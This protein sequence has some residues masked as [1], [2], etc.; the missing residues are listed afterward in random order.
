MLS[1][2]DDAVVDIMTRFGERIG[3]AFQLAD[4]IIDVA[5]DSTELGK[6][7]GTDLREG[8][9]TLPVLH[10]RRTAGPAAADRRLLEL[11]DRDLSEDALHAEA[12]ALLRAHPALEAARDDLRR[13]ADDARSVLD[14][15]PDG[16]ARD[17]LASLC[18]VV[19]S[20]TA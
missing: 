3:L 5:S 6:A 14:P 15:L 10:F 20:R 1:G 8:V 16:S 17:A 12:L 19:V 9:A 7:T 2:A 13:V 11:L 18:D 4:D